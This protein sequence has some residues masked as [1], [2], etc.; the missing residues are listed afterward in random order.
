M[1]SPS[2]TRAGRLRVLR[3]LSWIGSESAI[4]VLPFRIGIGNTELRQDFPLQRFHRLGFIL[5]F[6]IVADQMQKAVNREMAEMMMERL[7]LFVGFLAR[8]L[9]GDGN[10]AEHA[11]RIA[12]RA[13]TRP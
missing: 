8:R 6:V 1:T 13:R 3:G 2:C 7:F 5:R 10:I 11:R 4:S 9:V 12:G